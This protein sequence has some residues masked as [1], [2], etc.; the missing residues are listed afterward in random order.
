[1]L[2]TGSLRK[3]EGHR[4]LHSRPR[5]QS[6][7]S[8]METDK[9]LTMNATYKCVVTI[10]IVQ[11]NFLALHTAPVL[12]EGLAPGGQA[13]QALPAPSP[14]QTLTLVP[15]RPHTHG[16]ERGGGETLIRV[17]RPHW[18]NFPHPQASAFAQMTATACVP[19]LSASGLLLFIWW[20]QRG[21]QGMNEATLAR[22]VCRREARGRRRECQTLSADSKPAYIRTITTKRFWEVAVINKGLSRWLC[23]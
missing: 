14:R 8:G 5:T 1:M 6:E 12:R 10:A 18:T 16:Q 22:S 4:V 15:C 13:V 17:C 2:H 21:G 23:R 20:Q 9:K 7:N 19:A 11:K 3:C